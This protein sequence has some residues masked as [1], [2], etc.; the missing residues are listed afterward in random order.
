MMPSYISDKNFLKGPSGFSS[1]KKDLAY[2]EDRAEKNS[3]NATRAK[4]GA[5]SL[6]S[7]GGEPK[8]CS[9]SAKPKGFDGSDPYARARGNTNHAGDSSYMRGVRRIGQ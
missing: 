1:S 8:C 7:T 6:P 3:L 9:T 4:R 5:M 2:W